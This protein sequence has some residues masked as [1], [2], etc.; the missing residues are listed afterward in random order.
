M[1]QEFY[2]ILDITFLHGY[3][4]DH[5]FKTIQFTVT[6]TTQALI[7]NLGIV[8]KPLT[9]GMSVFS[10]MPE[11]LKSTEGNQ[12]PIRLYIHAID[13][14]F[15][16]Y[17]DIPGYA[18]MQTILYF[19]NLKN[20]TYLHESAFVGEKNV[21]PLSTGI[22]KIPNYKEGYLYVFRDVLGDEISDEYLQKGQYPDEY[23]LVYDREGLIRIFEEGELVSEVY[24]NP[25]TLWP[26][27]LGVIDIYP[28]QL[29][30]FNTTQKM[31]DYT[32]V[33]NNR[34]TFWRYIIIDPTVQLYPNLGIISDEGH[35]VFGPPKEMDVADKKAIVFESLEEIPLQEYTDVHFKLIH[36][37]DGVDEVIIKALAIASPNQL[38]PSVDVSM[39]SHI[40][41]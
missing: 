32:I 39:Y 12:E 4:K 36:K 15:I 40:Y 1:Q 34:K 7:R 21:V 25:N 19:N 8:L 30:D 33:F 14:S 27:P 18:P 23:R 20:G 28:S 5:R 26:P 13:P 10:S 17:S 16:N 2:H 38:F 6:E 11:L 22:L 24:F 3:F 31:H 37:K 41:I 29:A 35:N 9:G